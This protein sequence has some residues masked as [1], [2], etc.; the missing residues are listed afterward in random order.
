MKYVDWMTKQL[1]IL[2]K[3]WR[4]LHNYRVMGEGIDTD[5]GMNDE[6]FI[7]NQQAKKC[8]L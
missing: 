7:S 4:V 2:T 6:C 5:N 1:G 8:W 3:S